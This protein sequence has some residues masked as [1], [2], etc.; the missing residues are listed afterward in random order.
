L[1]APNER[2]PDT[3]GTNDRALGETDSSVNVVDGFDVDK[4]FATQRARLAL[5]GISLQQ[6][7]TGEYLAH[8][9]SM[10]RTLADASRVEDFCRLVGA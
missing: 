2:T 6:L 1:S 7:S 4:T 9:W 10:H 3:V 5:R 8:S